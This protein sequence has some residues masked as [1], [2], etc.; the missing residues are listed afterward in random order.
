MADVAN[1]QKNNHINHK[2]PVSN[3]NSTVECAT[4]HEARFI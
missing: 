4:S 1:Q 2:E 3:L